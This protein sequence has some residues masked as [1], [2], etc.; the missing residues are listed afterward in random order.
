VILRKKINE[1]NI[2]DE[3]KEQINKIL[4][5]DD[6]SDESITDYDN[7]DLNCL[8]NTSSSNSEE[9]DCECIG[10]CICEIN[11][12]INVITKDN[13]ELLEL[14]EGISDKD[15]K[16][17]YLKQLKEKYNLEIDKKEE[18]SYNIKDIYKKFQENQKTENPITIT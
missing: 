7:N 16:E 3:L 1:L 14:I 11:G 17:V 6:S 18:T 9:N 15:I 12:E 10:P 13:K 2:S 8:D 5:N 4:I